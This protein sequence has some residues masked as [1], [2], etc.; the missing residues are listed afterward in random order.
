MQAART[1]ERPCSEELVGGLTEQGL[2]QVVRAPRQG[3]QAQIHQA[4]EERLEPTKPP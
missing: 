2:V 3:G 1:Q 4:A